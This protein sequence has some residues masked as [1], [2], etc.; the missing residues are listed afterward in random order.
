MRAVVLNPKSLPHLFPEEPGSV[1][2]NR[3]RRISGFDTKAVL[4]FPGLGFRV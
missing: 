4:S 1:A 3:Y 2:L